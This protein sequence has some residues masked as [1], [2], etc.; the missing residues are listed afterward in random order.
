[1]RF[2]T[3][4]CDFMVLDSEMMPS[5]VETG[6]QSAGP[7]RHPVRHDGGTLAVVGLER[8]RPALVS[9]MMRPLRR[10]LAGNG[11]FA[12]LALVSRN[13]PVEE[14]GRPGQAY[15]YARTKRS[16]FRSDDGEGL[17]LARACRSSGCPHR[18]WPP[19]SSGACEIRSTPESGRDGLPQGQPNDVSSGASIPLPTQE[20]GV[21]TVRGD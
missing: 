7:C 6:P 14:A 18:P 19:G 10:L 13:G 5:D 11:P 16:G 17:V 12:E 3:I 15:G 8:L 9:R 20:S 2:L 4:Y 1:M 21:A